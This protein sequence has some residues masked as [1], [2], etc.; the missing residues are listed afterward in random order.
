[1]WWIVGATG[2]LILGLNRWSNRRWPTRYPHRVLE[3]VEPLLEVLCQCKF[4]SVLVIGHEGSDRFI[5]LAQR[6]AVVGT[7]HLLYGFPDAPWSRAFFPRLI[8]GLAAEGWEYRVR[9]TG[10][11]VVTRF[12]EVDL[13]GHRDV[14]FP[15]AMRLIRVT[16][17]ILNLGDDAQFTVSLSGSIDHARYAWDNKADLERQAEKPGVAGW[18]ARHC[19]RPLEG[20]VVRED[21][22]SGREDNVT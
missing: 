17:Q 7:E 6:S 10:A 19:L 22:M 18:A 15:E 9:E 2:V 11:G 1:M 5:Q 4:G 14:V 20:R 3:D 21:S 8:A 16:S 12:A 13:M